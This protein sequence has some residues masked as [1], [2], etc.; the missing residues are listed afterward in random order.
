[1]IRIFTSRRCLAHRAPGGY[2]ERPERLQAILDHLSASE[3]LAGAVSEDAEGEMGVDREMAETAILALHDEAYVARLRRA[4]ERGDGLIDSADNP[5]SPG[6]WD[7]AMAAVETTLAAARWAAAGA[8]DG[9]GEEGPRHAF[10]LVRPPGHHAEGDRAMGFCYFG[11]L[12]VAVQHLVDAPPPHGVERPAILDPDVHHGNGTQHLFEA[13]GDVYFASLH[14][15]PFYPGT[16]ARS[17]RGVGEG[18]G[19][20][21][22][23][24]LPAGTGDE[25]WLAVLDDDVLPALRA[26]GPDFLAVSAGFDAWRGD[27]LGGMRLTEAA[28]RGLGRR[29]AA[30]AAAHTRGRTLTVLEGGYDVSALGPLVEEYLAGLAEGGPE[31][32]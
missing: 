7:A 28:F 6:T 13:R 14:Q 5:V 2:P 16:G 17:E 22:N 21:R 1:M 10:A 3:S 9:D 18:E 4:V 27:P 32:D 12:A 11:N 8:A 30:L 25:E 19:T 23:V 15:W 26:F 20:T 29:M 31:A 24:P